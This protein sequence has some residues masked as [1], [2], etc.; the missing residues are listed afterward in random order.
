MHVHHGN[1]QE[2]VTAVIKSKSERPDGGYDLKLKLASYDV[3]SGLA[4]FVGFHRDSPEEWLEDCA[5]EFMFFRTSGECCAALFCSKEW[6]RGCRGPLAAV[7]AI[8]ILILDGE[9][10][11]PLPCVSMV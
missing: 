11:S 6:D 4:S 5:R 3:H 8:S 7:M 10:P 9:T 1:F 2:V